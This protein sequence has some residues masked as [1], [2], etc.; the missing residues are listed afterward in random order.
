[1]PILAS[2][3]LDC[4]PAF[5]ITALHGQSYS[6]EACSFSLYLAMGFLHLQQCAAPQFLITE[7]ILFTSPTPAPQ[8]VLPQAGGGVLSW[9]DCI[10]AATGEQAERGRDM[11]GGMPVSPAGTT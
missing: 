1:M 4:A 9:G 7:I 2:I 8:K 10:A 5:C 3:L 11:N 6:V